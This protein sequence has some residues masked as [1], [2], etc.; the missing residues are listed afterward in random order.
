MMRKSPGMT[1]IAVIALAVGIGAGAT[2]FEFINDLF[3]PKL[4]FA[5]ADRLVGIVNWDLAKGAPEV[6]SLYDFAA[7]KMQLTPLRL[8]A[9]ASKRG[10]GPTIRIFGRLAPGA[11]TV[12]RLSPGRKQ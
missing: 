11:R 6:R 10:E 7:W 2:Y 12:Q 5:G 4:S 9:A 8:D 1:V 3:R